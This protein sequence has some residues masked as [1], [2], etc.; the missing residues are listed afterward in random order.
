MK[1]VA[2]L[3]SK[4]GTG[5]SSLSHCLVYGAHLFGLDAVMVHTDQRPRVKGKRP[6]RYSQVATLIRQHE[7][8]DGLLVVDGAGNAVPVTRSHRLMTV[9]FVQLSSYTAIHE[10][11]IRNITP[12]AHRHQQLPLGP[13]STFRRRP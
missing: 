3:G 9:M 11:P 12:P 7:K 5:K 6:Y 4:G 10:Y 1:S 2:I 13:T 8:D